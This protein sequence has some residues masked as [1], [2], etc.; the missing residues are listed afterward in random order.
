MNF[1]L[2]LLAVEALASH[3]A[4]KAVPG[5][6]SWPRH[7]AWQALNRTLSGRLLA[8]SPPAAV[9]HP[10]Q[11]TFNQ[12]SCAYVT[13]AWQNS[14]FHADNPIS[15]EFENWNN[16][17]CIPD[18]SAPCSGEGYPVYVVNA[19]TAED[20]RAGIKFA[21]ENNVRLI[22]KGSGHDYLGR[23]NIL[24]VFFLLV[25]KVSRSSAPNSLSIWTR[26]IR[27]LDFHDCF[28]P[29]GCNLNINEPAV[30]ISA[31]V[32]SGDVYKAAALRNRTI[33]SGMSPDISIGGYLTGGGHSPL[34][35]TYGLAADQVLEMQ[36]VTAEGEILI[37]NECQN[38]DLFWAL[39]GGGGST[40][41]VISSATVR[42]FPT[43][44]IGS[45]LV[46]VNFTGPTTDTFWETSAY[47]HQQISR[48][49]NK[50]VS[51]YYFQNPP[52]LSSEPN[53]TSPG[54][55]I[56]L[57][58]VV[59]QS[60]QA[61]EGYFEPIIEHIN[62]T[63]TNEV[64]I[65]TYGQDYEAFYDWWLVDS[66]VAAVG[67]DSVMG[68]RLLN[69][70]VLSAPSSS[71]IDA[72]NGGTPIVYDPLGGFGGNIVSG[73]GVWHAKPR[74]GG[75]SVNPAWRN[76]T[77]DHVTITVTFPPLNATARDDQH[78]LLTTRYVE[79]WRKFAPHSGAY[80]NEADPKEPKYQHAFWGENYPRLLSIKRK[81]DPHDVF[82][83]QPCVGNE[84][85][86]EV[87]NR[88]CRT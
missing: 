16:D 54:S 51:G 30:T 38:P 56:G 78:R 7:S 24:I 60:S 36:V 21:G 75:N 84:R 23:Y 57:F 70:D 83:C 41:A 53:G 32:L 69:A 63:F 52:I 85:W 58:L 68:S 40:Y 35:A 29:S 79:A 59:N 31:G 62:R 82:W 45:Y 81:I 65:A 34:S 28:N 37:A 43:P 22:V 25:T 2:L 6:T 46:A 87:G 33:V 64:S 13:S 67:Y 71:L 74:G 8:P 39:R 42:T 55:F 47:F 77:V 17:S 48:L 4:C 27:G 11:P 18:P 9:C 5:S 12:S 72:I 26:Y 1:F 88:L 10:D 73:P 76:G 50:G 86:H 44:A 66:D 15:V 61:A 49:V 80:I 14:T 19:T 20:V 3:D